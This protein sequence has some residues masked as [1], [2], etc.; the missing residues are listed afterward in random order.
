MDLAHALLDPKLDVFATLDA[1][2]P[3]APAPPASKPGTGKQQKGDAAT[4]KDDA[5]PKKVKVEQDRE[6]VAAA[7]PD[8]P[9]RELM[10]VS[11]TFISPPRISIPNGPNCGYLLAALEAHYGAQKLRTDRSLLALLKTPEPKRAPSKWAN[12][13]MVN[14]EPLYEAFDRV[15]AE[16]KTYDELKPFQRKVSQREVPDYHDVIKRPMDFGS[17]RHKLN[18]YQYRSKHEFVADLELIYTNCMT[19][20]SHPDSIYRKY[21]EFLKAKIDLIAPRIPDLIVYKASEPPPPGAAPANA[22]AA[23]GSAA[24]EKLPRIK[25]IP[26]HRR[27]NG[28]DGDAASSS[29]SSSRVDGK[30]APVS[31]V[32]PS[33]MFMMQPA[34]RIDPRA[35][36][37]IIPL[38]LPPSPIATAASTAPPTSL[39]DLSSAPDGESRSSGSSRGKRARS[40]SLSNPSVG[41]PALPPPAP[42]RRRSQSPI[43]R[44]EPVTPNGD[45]DVEVEEA[46]DAD[47]ELVQGPRSHLSAI[48]SM[49]AW[50]GLRNRSAY[51]TEMR[52]HG[53][54]RVAPAIALAGLPPP[55]AAGGGSSGGADEAQQ[56]ASGAA[57]TRMRSPSPTRR[58][59]SPGRTVR[60]G[61]LDAGTAALESDID[62]LLIPTLAADLDSI[63]PGGTGIFAAQVADGEE[64]APAP[65]A[66]ADPPP[67]TEILHQEAAH[68][69]LR[70]AL[71]LL[72]GHSGF[73]GCSANVIQVLGDLWVQCLDKLGA[74]LR[75]IGDHRPSATT[76]PLSEVAPATSSAVATLGN[77]QPLP[78]AEEFTPEHRLSLALKVNGFDALS[79]YDHAALD[80]CRGSHRLVDLDR[81][82]ENKL[83]DM[84][85]GGSSRMGLDD[86]PMEDEDDAFA[87]GSF[88]SGLLGED[89]FGFGAVGVPAVHA[90]P[91][92]L[93]YK[94][95]KTGYYRRADAAA[96]ALGANASDAAPEFPPPPG[97]FRPLMWTVMDMEKL[98][99]A[100]AP[101]PSESRPDGQVNGFAP[102][103]D[104]GASRPPPAGP[105]T[106]PLDVRPVSPAKRAQQGLPPPAPRSPVPKPFS[107]FLNFSASLEP[108]PATSP[109][110]P[111][112]ASAPNESRTIVRE[113]RRVVVAASTPPPGDDG[114]SDVPAAHAPVI[115]LMQRWWDAHVRANK[116]TDGVHIM[117]DDVRCTS[118]ELRVRLA[119]RDARAAKSVQA[120]A[121]SATTTAG[122]S[123]SAGAAAAKKGGKKAKT[124]ATAAAAAGK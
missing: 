85:T 4:Q 41:D 63:V 90:V 44:S 78:P 43:Q 37:P 124:A 26:G 30:L 100:H 99:D 12:P 22:P 54:L 113:P 18:T 104:E 56:G 94:D 14:Q 7:A 106:L 34:L 16:L 92:R 9:R 89:F 73:D 6:P 66:G 80:I 21:G 15:L 62:P 75:I 8:P 45:L 74:S 79:I 58:S 115:G 27:A 82:V 2:P 101:P 17:M 31:I 32:P 23:S 1:D 3:P 68:V 65:P 33:G 116:F 11:T 46:V 96:D 60:S 48:A 107:S 67:P 5:L 25:A 69:Y 95:A 13:D 51:I 110:R 120:S 35:P 103:G 55:P 42:K 53:V 10:P 105:A 76:E 38:P 19:F 64:P 72:L 84:I 71:A 97:K 24:T 40:A 39:A 102:P 52:D 91:S 87:S 98:P 36:V 77:R 86:L 47:A 29:S 108:S 111:T 81:R 121:A 20:N 49:R 122:S 109:D 114:E 93:W 119:E 112:A 57:A 61:S 83:R 59:T 117:E 118:K 88:L 70:R 123:T 50:R 28:V